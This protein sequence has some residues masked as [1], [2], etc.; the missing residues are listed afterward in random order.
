M[1]KQLERKSHVHTRFKENPDQDILNSWYINFAFWGNPLSS[2]LSFQSMEEKEPWRKYFK[3]NAGDYYLCVFLIIKLYKIKTGVTPLNLTGIC[4][5]FTVFS[6]CS[7]CC[8]DMWHFQEEQ[9]C[10]RKLDYAPVLQHH[11]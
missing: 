10:T 2:S 1:N 6:D 11:L 8:C 9:Y 4:I 7:H 3:N 5:W